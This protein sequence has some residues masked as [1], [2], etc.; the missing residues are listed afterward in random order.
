MEF[1]AYQKNI[2]SNFD[3][4]VIGANAS[5]TET[6]GITIVCGTAAQNGG[7][8]FSDGSAAGADA[9]RGMI[10]YVHGGDNANSMAFRTGGTER[11][12]FDTSGRFMT[13]KTSTGLEKPGVE[14]H[15][16]DNGFLGTTS[17][18]ATLHCNREDSD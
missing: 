10:Q 16:A 4:L 18:G 12:R 15:T 8:A 7:I 2:N 9:Y 6:H 17:T 14:T 5:T 11:G 3:D 1:N 13:R